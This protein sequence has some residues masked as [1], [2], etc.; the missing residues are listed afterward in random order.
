MTHDT[1]LLAERLY[2]VWPIGVPPVPTQFWTAGSWVRWEDKFRPADYAGGRYDSA[3]W[4]HFDAE[5][6]EAI[7]DELR[8]EMAAQIG[9]HKGQEAANKWLAEARGMA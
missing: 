2:C 3:A 1:Q 8:V 6:R 5:R 7:H 4:E 9:R